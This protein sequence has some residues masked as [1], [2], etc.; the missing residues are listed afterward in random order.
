MLAHK[1]KR[2]NKPQNTQIKHNMA[3]AGFDSWATVLQP[4]MWRQHS[5]DVSGGGTHRG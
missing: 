4:V 3:E 2:K 5:A 1:K